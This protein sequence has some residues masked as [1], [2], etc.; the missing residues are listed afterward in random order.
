MSSMSPRSCCGK[1]SL[2]GNRMSGCTNDDEDVPQE[3]DLKSHD[4]FKQLET[5]D[6]PAAIR[7][8]FQTGQLDTGGDDPCSPQ[9]A[10]CL[11][12][13]TWKAFPP[14][15]AVLTGLGVL[16]LAAKD[17]A[18]NQDILTHIFGRIENC[19]VRLEIYIGVPLTPAMTDKMVQI[20]VE[21]FDVLATVT[22]EMK[23][24]AASFTRLISFQKIPQEGDGADGSGGW[25]EEAHE[26]SYEELMLT[27]ARPQE[28][29][30][31]QRERGGV[32]EN[33]Q[34][35]KSEAAKGLTTQ[36]TDSN[37]DYDVAKFDTAD[38]DRRRS[39]A[40]KRR[41]ERGF[42]KKSGEARDLQDSS[43]REWLQGMNLGDGGRWGGRI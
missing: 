42:M 16:L 1:V 19:S 8:V 23:R 43:P 28:R 2:G 4:L 32:D 25:D 9:S 20:T 12:R 41:R 5:C 29:D 33:V 22:K 15:K 7:A 36:N 26:L 11:L 37:D 35:V 38:S 34:V 24:G 39:L 31:G 30:G 17:V 10:L 6:F 27:R 40:K 14:A 3:K 18:E 21:I 13:Y